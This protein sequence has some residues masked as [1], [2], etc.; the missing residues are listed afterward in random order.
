M[1]AK[2]QSI[3]RTLSQARSFAKRGDLMR[4]EE[5]YRDVLARFPQNPRALSGLRAL[6]DDMSADTAGHGR[7]TFGRSSGR[8]PETRSPAARAV[9]RGRRM[10]VAAR[11]DKAEEAFAEA[12]SLDPDSPEAHCGHSAALRLLGRNREAVMAARRAIALRPQMGVAHENLGSA[13]VGLDN[14]PEA[15]MA[16]AEAMRLKPS[17]TETYVNTAEALMALGK[18]EE[19]LSSFRIALKIKPDSS[20]I[21]NQLG[22]SLNKMGRHSEAMASLMEALKLSSDPAPVHNNLG[23]VLGAMGE[24]EAARTSFTRSIELRPDN[25]QAHFNL[26][27]YKKFTPEDPH[28]EQ[29]RHLLARPGVS[30]ENAMFYNFSLGKAFEDLGEWEASLGHYVEGNRLRKRASGYEFTS[31]I[32]LFAR[33]RSLFPATGVPQLAEEPFDG[34]RPIFVLGMPRSGTSLMEQ[35]LAS[36]SEVHGAG[37]LELLARAAR[38]FV[39]SP[40]MEP[41]LPLTGDELRLARDDYRDGVAKLG[42]GTPVFVDKMPLNFRFVGFVLAAMPEARVIHME[43]D[44]MA[45]CWSVFKHR[46]SS[47]GNGYAYDMEDL[48]HYF[49]LYRELMAYWHALFPGRILDVNYEQL[50]EHQEDE[51]RRALDYAGLDWQEACLDFYRTKRSVMTASANQVR[52]KMYKGSSEAWHDYE[53]WLGPLKDALGDVLA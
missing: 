4:A 37:E 26:A 16:F 53:P 10:M 44:P 35:I 2:P 15:L 51:T 25:G 40:G 42:I 29:L 45:T 50:T 11:P 8:M 1:S 36:H 38:R 33:I 31:D 28:I 41:G 19:A 52:K 12:I 27:N 47:R 48:G 3:D 5:L 21:H 43:R 14:H 34:P 13:L 32:K 17:H 39:V 9:D 6:A 30:A 23:T 20:R 22:T 7:A 18:Y 24:R 49:R 46:F